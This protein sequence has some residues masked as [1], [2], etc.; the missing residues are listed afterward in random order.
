VEYSNDGRD[1]P[2]SRKMGL[3]E[4]SVEEIGEEKDRLAMEVL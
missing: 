1:F 4:D 2:F 3:K